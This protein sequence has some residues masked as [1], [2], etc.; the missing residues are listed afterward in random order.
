MTELQPCAMLANGP[1][2]M[3]AGLFSSV[4]TRFGAIASFKRAA[5]E[6]AAFRSADRTGW[7]SRVCPTTI[8]A[9]RRRRSARS[10]ERQKIAITSEATVMSNPSSRAKP[11]ATPPSEETIERNAR[12]ET[13]IDV[14]VNE[15]GEQV[16]GGADRVQITGEMQVDVFHRH[17]LRIA[18]AGG[19]ALDAKAR[20]EARLAQAE[21]RLL[22]DVV[23]RV[24]ETD[25]CRRLAFAGRR[26]GDRRDEDQLALRP[27]KRSEEHTSE[28]QSRV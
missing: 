13:V 16:V 14:V 12:V 17:D 15:R 28:L 22:A 2:W 24:A 18:A 4:W 1:P 23:E 20:P 6:P 10:V 5:I 21:D 19:A 8:L 9:S 3:K 27:A 7:R 11:L 26:R 25:R